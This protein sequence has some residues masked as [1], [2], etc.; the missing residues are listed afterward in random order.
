[1]KNKVIPVFEYGSLTIGLSYG[2][3]DQKIVF[4]KRHYQML[5]SFLANNPRCSYF[6]LLGNKIQFCNYVGV[7][8]AADLSIEVLPKTDRD[9]WDQ[10]AW[11]K[12]LVKMLAISLEV[13]AKPTTQANLSLQ[14]N[15]VLEAYLRLFLQE[16]AMLIH[17][18]LV[19]K[20]RKETANQPSLKGRLLIHKHVSK[21]IAHA[22]RLYVSFGTYDRNNVYNAILYEALNCILILGASND[23]LHLASRLKADFPVCDRIRVAEILFKKLTFDRKTERYKPAIELAR[24]ILM[25]YHPDV[26]GGR[27]N[28]LAIMF[29]MNDLWEIYVFKMILRAVRKQALSYQLLPQSPRLFW[30]RPDG[31]SMTLIPD[32]VLKQPDGQTIVLDTKWKY[33]RDTSAQ[34]VRQMYAYGHY[35]GANRRYLLYP[36]NIKTPALKKEGAFYEI[37]RRKIST[38]EKCGFVL[39]NL[40]NEDHTLNLEIGAHIL[41]GL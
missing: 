32:I 22:E 39:I 6:R 20:Y 2:Y 38:T 3:D 7:I 33:R 24:I 18:G 25:N 8:K 36:D 4:E 9:Q 37:D 16:T 13:K 28:I 23:I 15:S 11:Q 10:Q 34:D 29:D 30:Q 31:R 40:L 1:M 21:N 14:S 27:N 5:E 26:A 12:V 35:F 19:K 41:Q 17:Q